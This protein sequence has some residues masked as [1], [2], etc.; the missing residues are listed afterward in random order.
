[1][2][3]HCKLSVGR[4]AAGSFVDVVLRH[5]WRAGLKPG[6]G[7]YR[8]RVRLITCEACY[9]PGFYPVG[10]LTPPRREPGLTREGRREYALESVR[11]PKVKVVG[12]GTTCQLKRSSR[13]AYG[14][15]WGG[16]GLEGEAMATWI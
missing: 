1:M 3:V 2:C 8:N 9:L 6:A 15:E 10:Q 7:R 14:S 4:V 5:G 16:K 13:S 11:R 12:E